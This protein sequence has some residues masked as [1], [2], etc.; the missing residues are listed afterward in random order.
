MAGE[1]IEAFY[2]PQGLEHRAGSLRSYVRHAE[3]FLPSQLF[4]KVSDN[5]KELRIGREQVLETG[6]FEFK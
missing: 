3:D 2:H 6:V 5:I 1:V 4:L